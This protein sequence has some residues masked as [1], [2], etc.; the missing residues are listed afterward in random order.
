MRADS[1]KP[2]KKICAAS[3]SHGRGFKFKYTL[4]RGA[5]ANG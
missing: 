1:W 2:I 5:G 4:A 3:V